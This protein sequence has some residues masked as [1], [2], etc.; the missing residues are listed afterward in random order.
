MAYCSKCLH[1]EVCKTADSCDGKVPGC[2]YFK[3]KKQVIYIEELAK[4]ICDSYEECVEGECPGFDYCYFRGRNGV[5]IWLENVI[6]GK[7]EEEI[8]DC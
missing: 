4:K 3:D 5:Q 8:E 6:K 1:I 7:K 2:Q